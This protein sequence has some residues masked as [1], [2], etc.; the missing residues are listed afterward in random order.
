M[1]G[2]DISDT[3]TA[4]QLKDAIHVLDSEARGLRK[5]LADLARKHRATVMLGRTHG[6]AAVPMTF[7]LK[8]AVFVSEV[9][10]HL[11]RLREAEGRVVVGK[12]S[13]AVGTGAALGP[14]GAE[15]VRTYST[16]LSKVGNTGASPT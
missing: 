8:I 4:L 1:I 13:G 11:V 15:I 2:N 16:A 9:D 7:G 12:M 10:R 14:K 3:A 6:Q 5:A